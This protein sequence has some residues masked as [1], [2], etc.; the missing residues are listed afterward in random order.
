MS[1]RPN[2][3]YERSDMQWNELSRNGLINQ[4][5]GGIGQYKTRIITKF[6]LNVTKNYGGSILLGRTADKKYIV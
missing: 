5:L 3:C 4:I 1:H 2:K 6:G